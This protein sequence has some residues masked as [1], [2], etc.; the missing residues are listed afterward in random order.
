MD[1]DKNGGKLADVLQEAVLLARHCDLV[2]VSQEPR[3]FK[4]WND[5]VRFK[6][7]DF[8]PTARVSSLDLAWC[9]ALVR[10]TA[11][12]DGLKDFDLLTLAEVAEL[13]HC[14]K[15]HVSNA[16]AGR[17]AGCPPIPAVRLGRRKLVRRE[18]LLAWIDRNEKAAAPAMIPVSP[19]RGAVKRA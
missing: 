19:V 17:V 8:F 14:S 3:G 4:D 2:F 1:A 16:V 7:A 18:T 11:F 10:S 5:E 15:A 13:L 12:M 6:Q 9:S